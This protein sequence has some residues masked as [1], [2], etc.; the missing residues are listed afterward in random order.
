NPILLIIL[1]LSCVSASAQERLRRDQSF[2]GIHFDFH[3]GAADKNI[4]ANTTPEMVGTILDMVR[5]DYIQ[6]DCKGHPGYSSYPT[7]VG[8]PA[9]GLVTDP[10][11][12]WRK[13]TADRGV[14]LYMHYSGVWDARA[15]ELNPGWAVKDPNGNPSATITSVFGPYVDKLLIPQLKELAGEYKVDGMWVDGEC[16]ATTMDYG[17]RAVRLFKE[18]TGLDAPR[19]A[20]EP[21]WYEWKQFNREAF[22]KYLR[23]YIA[24]VR[25][26]YP[27]FQIC[28]N[29]AYTHHMSEPVSA[30]VDFLSGDYSSTNSVNSARVAARYLAWQGVPWDLMA[31]SFALTDGAHI[32]KPSIQLIREAA[33][34]LS[35]GGG[36]QAYYTQNRDGSLNLDKLKSMADVA[37]FARARQPYC[38]HSV[39][40]PQVAVLVS[41][42]DYQHRNDALFPNTTGSAAGIL[43]CLLESQYSVDL[44]GEASLEPDMSR[45][46]LIVVPECATLSEVFRDDLLEYVKAG[47]ALLVVGK[48]MTEFFKSVPEVLSPVPEVLSPVPELVEGPGEW[49]A[50]SLGKGKI[51]FIPEEIAGDYEAGKGSDGIMARVN[52][53][54]NEL[55]PEPMVEV[56]SSPYVDVSLRTLNG[57]LQVHLVNTSGDHR[58]API[59]ETIDPVQKLEVTV[60]CPDKPSKIVSQPSGKELRF[61]YRNGKVTFKIPSLEIYDII[62]L[63]F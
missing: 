46:P 34:T 1:I 4:G 50:V 63:S 24:A 56:A 13:V 37:V 47:G 27:D 3:A 7:K 20:N 18:E 11:K 45:F 62:E 6:V 36:F 38:H 59:L 40:V 32:Q 33:V 58:N 54:V 39:S 16:W 42:Y 2:L 12:V 30:P 21:G 19:S 43:N 26:E 57:K 5:P 22:R 52:V 31:W 17:E 15:V 55:F 61:K 35:Q 9:P 23:H 14:G 41:T 48:A 53:L 8:N 51:G 29:W 28:S 60:R 44:L 10:L 49:R 25:S